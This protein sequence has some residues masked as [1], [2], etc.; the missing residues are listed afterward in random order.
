MSIKPK[1]MP[2]TKE[3]SVKVIADAETGRILG[4]QAIGE[5]GTDW[6]IN[7]IALAIKQRMTLQELST[8][9]LAYCPAVSDLYDPLLV[10][11]DAALR[12]LEAYARERSNLLQREVRVPERDL[13]RTRVS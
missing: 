9:E 13:I 11:V 8:I 4:G 1:W 10:A 7:I 2:D 5:K 6:R 3:I 12:R